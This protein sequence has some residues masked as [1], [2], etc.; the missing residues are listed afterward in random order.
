MRNLL[1]FLSLFFTIIINAQG[2]GVISGKITENETNFSLPGATIRLAETNKYTTSD[3]NGEFEFLDIT[4]GT[5][6]IEVYYIGYQKLSK[7]T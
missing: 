1:L 6:K 7:E 4:E 5:Y 3:I 2:K